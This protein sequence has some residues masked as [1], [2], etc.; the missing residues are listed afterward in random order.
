MVNEPRRWLILSH[1][2][3][4]DGRAE[5]LTITDK[6]PYLID[7]GIEPVIFSSLMGRRDSH[8]VHCQFLPWG[9]AGL[10]FD[11]RHVLQ[12][13]WGRN[14]A[15]KLCIFSLSVLLA[16]LILRHFYKSSFQAAYLPG[17]HQFLN[18]KF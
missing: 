2:Y 5:S 3:N 6:I 10:R 1:A 17:N 11:L 4:V 18:F 13:R 15:Y 8:H 9:P 12:R 16:P 14:V 7:A